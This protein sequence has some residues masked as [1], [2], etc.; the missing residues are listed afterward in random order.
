MATDKKPVFMA[1]H[2][3]EKRSFRIMQR[4]TRTVTK[5]RSAEQELVAVHLEGHDGWT[6]PRDVI[7]FRC[8]EDCKSCHDHG[9]CVS[10]PE[11]SPFVKVLSGFVATA[12][13]PPE[14]KK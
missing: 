12:P 8:R 4:K 6:S 10:V 7:Q 2:L 9:K 11:D 3:Q 13:N 5:G 1:Y 14:E